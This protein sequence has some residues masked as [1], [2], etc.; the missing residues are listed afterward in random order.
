ML[1]RHINWWS[2]TILLEKDAMMKIEHIVRA[3]DSI[4]IY[5]IQTCDIMDMEFLLLPVIDTI[6]TKIQHCEYPPIHILIN[7][8][9][10]EYMD[11]TKFVSEMLCHFSSFFLLN[12][13]YGQF[14]E[15]GYQWVH[16]STRPA[17]GRIIGIQ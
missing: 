2:T 14:L 4:H 17:K 5:S 13:H 11:W 8:L 7:W 9:T 3:G 10:Y 1:T 16:T 15:T 6:L 12:F